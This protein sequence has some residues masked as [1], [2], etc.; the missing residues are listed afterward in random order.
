MDHVTVLSKCLTLLYLE[1]LIE[2][3]A[4]HSNDLIKT[5]IDRIIVSDVDIG[6]TT[7]R[8]TASGL[9]ELI[10]E[11]IRRADSSTLIKEDLLQQLKLAT[12]G[13]QVVYDAIVQGMVDDPD[14]ANTKRRI[15]ALKKTLST[16]FREQKAAEMLKK[17]SRDMNFNRQALGDVSQYLKNL[18]TELD[19]LTAK[20]VGKDPG[21]IRSLDFTDENSMQEI[22]NDVASSNGD[23]LPFKTGWVELDEGLQGGPRPGDCVVIGALQHNYKTGTSLSMFTHIPIF[24]K[25][26]NKDP[27]K[28]P[29]CYR[30]S[31]EDP[32]R[33]NAQF[34]YQLLKYEETGEA[35]SLKGVPVDEMTAYVK[36]RMSIN[37]YHVKMDEVNPLTWT[38]H[39]VISRIIDLESQGYVVEVLCIDYLSK[40]PTTGCTQ[41]SIGDDV[42]DLLSRVRAYCASR[43][44]LFITPHQLNTEAKRIAVAPDQLL[45]AIKGGGFFEKTRGLDR[46]YDIGILQHKVETPNG[47]FLH[48]LIDKHRFPSVIDS[49]KKSW[50]L[51]FPSNKMPIPSNYDQQ[52]YRI[53]RKIPRGFSNPDDALFG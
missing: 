46:V 53:L 23:E 1:S 44:I 19:I 24:N 47:D 17:A 41:G 3:N 27:N 13:D 39:N 11:I 51:K 7:R 6:M 42:L 32:I 35:V 16:Y 40:L 48:M 50:Y 43:G 10:S 37:G 2:D 14:Q 29:L 38:Y 52:D 33:N 36:S 20:N 30:I 25:P 34:V 5:V 31:L 18:I 4:N 49:S 21:L 9:K 45:F 15:T 28:K 22:Y 26:K 8:S 12:N